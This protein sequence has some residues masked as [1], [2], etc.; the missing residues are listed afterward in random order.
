MNHS[1]IKVGIICP[2]DI[3]YKICKES[4]K[5]HNATELSGRFISSRKDNDIEVLAVKAG[6]GKINCSSATQLIID[7][8]Q[9][10]F[11]FDVGVAGSLTEAVKI[12]DIVCGKYV[13]E[14]DACTGEILDK[15]IPITWSSLNV[16]SY[17]E[18]LYKFI[19]WAKDTMGI[20]IMIGNIASGEKDVKSTKF[21]QILHENFNAIVCNWESSSILQTAKFNEKKR[22]SFRVI[23]DFADENMNDYFDKNCGLALKKMFPVLR[24]FIFKGW[25]NKF[26]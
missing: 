10:D 15:D 26:Y 1:E 22:F 17:Q 3:E 20:N 7:K 18:V 11:I 23:V 24:E 6:V 16:A 5:L 21:K 13:F 2:L 9:P 12:F 8:F 25:I 19:K 4:L 14:Y